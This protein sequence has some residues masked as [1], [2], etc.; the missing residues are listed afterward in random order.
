MTKATTTLRIED[1]EDG[2]D[3]EQKDNND[4]QITQQ[5]SDKQSQ[6]HADD[7]KGNEVSFDKNSSDR[8]LSSPSLSFSDFSHNYSVTLEDRGA[9]KVNY[10]QQHDSI[11]GKVHSPR[12]SRKIIPALPLLC[13]RHDA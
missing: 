2:N 13:S 8:R 6:E 1:K 7:V 9:T 12:V 10:Q 5:E 3:S 4:K 11:K